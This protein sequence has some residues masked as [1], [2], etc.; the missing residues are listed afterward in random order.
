MLFL[1]TLS[2][3][4]ID[5]VGYWEINNIV[6]KYYFEI[7][8]TELKLKK[9]QDIELRGSDSKARMSCASPTIWGLLP[10]PRKQ[11]KLI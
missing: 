4:N 7:K 5:E 11:A 2:R 6:I 10:L 1:Y 3:I 8:I 9:A